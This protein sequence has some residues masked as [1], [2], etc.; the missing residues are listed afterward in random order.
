M[1]KAQLEQLEKHGNYISVPHGNS[2]YPMIR[3][4]K[5]AV[6]IKKLEHRPRRYDLVLYIRGEDQGV[7][8]RVLYWKKDICV[9]CGDNC[10]QKEY[11]KPE[12][13][14]GIVTKYYRNGTW[15]A[16]HNWK[17]RLY[18]HL[19][20]DFYLIR[21]PLFWIRDQLK[22]IR[23]WHIP[24]L[25]GLQM[26]LGISSTG[27]AFLLR[28][29]IDA[30]VSHQKEPMLWNLLLLVLLAAVQL[31]LG[32]AVRF[33]TELSK[34]SCEN[35]WKKR[36]FQQILNRDYGEVTAVH[37]E[38]WMNHL[39]SDTAVVADGMATIVPG[40]A[41]MAI[42]LAGAVGMLFMLEPGF[43]G[44]LLAGGGLMA[45][46]ACFF[47]RKLKQLHKQVQ[48][49]DGKMRSF[50]QEQITSLSVL[51]VFGREET[52]LSR[53]EEKME[54][55]KK[56]R[57]DR[58]R[59]S[60]LCS[61]GFSSAMNGA[62]VL[63]IF[64]C[65]LGLYHGSM[66]YGTL[67]AVI[68]L[69]G[70]IRNPFAAIT[71]YLPKYY[72]MEASKERLRAVEMLK[73]SSKDGSLSAG[74]VRRLYEEQI[75]SLVFDQVTFAYKGKKAA[76]RNLSC[77][78]KKGEAVAVTG[79]SGCGKST[80][81]KLLMG[82]YEPDE[83]RIGA[84]LWNG[85]YRP[86]HTMQRLFA[87]VPQGNLLM[88]GT[89]G[90][91]ITFQKR[92]T[93]LKNGEVPERAVRLQR[94]VAL[95]CAEFIYELPE[96]MDT[97]LGE[98]GCGLSEGQMQR[99]AIARALYADTPVLILDEATSALDAETEERLLVNLKG[100]T[101]KTIFLVTHRMKALSVCDRQLEIK[102]ANE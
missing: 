17:Y 49:K 67:M 8:H 52:S 84:P 57:M 53:A 35:E 54:Q 20:T 98:R 26:A 60:N 29:G 55:Y 70:Q 18:V 83:G 38:E 34:V 72:A 41:G 5:D 92:G 4:G 68:Q 66:S 33:F 10:W 62:Y 75:E 71:G 73:P 6:E 2:M 101:D 58:N 31:I 87:Y 79:A 37:S 56:A 16:V 86:V 45:L 39:T 13:I 90:E 9:I 27:Y 14:K 94:A 15:N 82:L 22:K 7:I 48:E 97:V 100:L 89:I 64:Y 69:V 12:Q 74:E 63:G 32:T 96:G 78:V 93:I 28:G 46:S 81:L 99:I 51:K 50:L 21:R 85:E 1:G 42:K 19:W 3:E 36:L 11:V 30:A 40:I 91:I 77:Q 88:S 65:V 76:L 61:L 43:A 80:F 59:Y 102:G 44:V 23:K 95:A 47:R 25:M 24:V